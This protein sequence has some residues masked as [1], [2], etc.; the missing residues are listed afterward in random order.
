[1]QDGGDSPSVGGCDVEPDDDCDVEDGDGPRMEDDG[2]EDGKRSLAAPRPH[3]GGDVEG[4][5]EEEEQPE[6]EV[7]EGRVAPEHH[8]VVQEEVAAVRELT[9]V[10]SLS[11]LLEPSAVLVVGASGVEESTLR[12]RFCGGMYF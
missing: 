11:F 6:E 3:V 7:E 9:L 1:M 8:A 4:A 5:E 10:E 2:V 12:W